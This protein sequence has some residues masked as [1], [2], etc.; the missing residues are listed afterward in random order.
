[1]SEAPIDPIAAVSVPEPV[2]AEAPAPEHVDEVAAAKEAEVAKATAEEA[3]IA[4]ARAAFQEQ[5]E[6]PA[7]LAHVQSAFEQ[8]AAKMAP[9]ERVLGDPATQLILI[10]QECATGFA[11]FRAEIERLNGENARMREALGIVEEAAEAV[12]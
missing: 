4:K 8:V 7:K 12:S 6:Q 10:A 3:E 2:A 11:R 1:M 9:I 5:M